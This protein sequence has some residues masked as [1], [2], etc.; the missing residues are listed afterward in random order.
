MR[1]TII[2]HDERISNIGANLFKE[3][4]RPANCHNGASGRHADG[5]PK[6]LSATTECD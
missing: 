4:E 2:T 6:I 1:K 5:R 3:V